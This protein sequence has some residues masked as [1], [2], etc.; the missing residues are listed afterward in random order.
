MLVLSR[1]EG[2]QIV[3]YPS[4]DPP[5]TV[6]VLSRQG[7][8]IRLGI[9]APANVTVLRSE[10]VEEEAGL[11]VEGLGSRARRERKGGRG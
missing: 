4:G 1:E 2:Q 11:R 7:N 5:I 3:I 8:H 6:T 10:L 9:D